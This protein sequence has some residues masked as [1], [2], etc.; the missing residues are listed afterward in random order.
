[1]NTERAVQLHQNLVVLRGMFETS[2]APAAKELIAKI[3]LELPKV[4]NAII[5]SA[6]KPSFP[7]VISAVNMKPL[8]R[9][10]TTKYSDDELLNIILGLPKYKQY[11]LVSKIIAKWGKNSPTE[12]EAD[13]PK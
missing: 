2:E 11:E 5:D 8:R 10:K 3:D 7:P 13:E 12:I 1:M 9:T 4:I 6:S